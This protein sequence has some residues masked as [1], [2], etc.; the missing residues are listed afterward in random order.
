MEKFYKVFASVL[1]SILI[2]NCILTIDNCYSQWLQMHEGINKS[3]TQEG[4]NTNSLKFIS[5]NV[6]HS[7][8]KITNDFICYNNQLLD[9]TKEV[10]QDSIITKPVLPDSAAK[11]SQDSNITKPVLA[12]STNK[13]TQD[14]IKTNLNK[15]VLL[16]DSTKKI[17]KDS[18]ITKTKIPGVKTDLLKNVEKIKITKN[19]ITFQPLGLLL[20]FT[21]IEYDRAVTDYFSVGC[22]ISTTVFYFVM[23]L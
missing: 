20:F 3:V 7:T 19:S 5:N 1:L 22:K 2:V 13:V 18:L 6:F 12:D 14:S 10:S 11:V 9:S 23:Q 21:N 4:G 8:Q 17:V 16:S 15:P